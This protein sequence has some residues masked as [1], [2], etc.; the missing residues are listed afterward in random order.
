MKDKD[1]EKV[2]VTPAKAFQLRR[3]SLAP[4]DTRADEAYLDTLAMV[5]RDVQD[6]RRTLPPRALT[7]AERKAVVGGTLIP[8]GTMP[9]RR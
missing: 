3:A 6:A 5:E 8:N 2:S 7:A 4:A 9:E 1:E